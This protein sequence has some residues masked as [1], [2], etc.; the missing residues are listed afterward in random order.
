MKLILSFD[1]YCEEN[2]KLMQLLKKYELEKYTIWFIDLRNKEAMK[3]IKYL[4]GAG[5]EIGCHTFSHPPDLKQLNNAELLNEI[6]DAKMMIEGIINKPICWF[7]PPRGRYDNRVIRLISG[8]YK[9]LRTVDLFNIKRRKDEYIKPTTIHIY[10]RKE[11][12]GRHWLELAK[13]WFLKAKKENETFHIWGHA[14]EI[15]RLNEWDNL[16][17]FFKF[18]KENYNGNN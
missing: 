1:D 2:Y 4:S 13:E 14:E 12:N 17:I 7:C 18:L 9:Y 8:V 6:I 10:P 15:N 3:Q 11:Y 16:E 5:F